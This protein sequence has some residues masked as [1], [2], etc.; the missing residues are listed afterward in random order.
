MM[1]DFPIEKIALK[2]KSVGT[3]GMYVWLND[4][5]IKFQDVLTVDKEYLSDDNHFVL[6][7]IFHAAATKPEYM[8]S[9]SCP[10]FD[11]TKPILLLGTIPTYGSQAIT[12]VNSSM[13]CNMHEIRTFNWASGMMLG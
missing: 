12:Y 7:D 2:I 6:N 13:P 4:K 3:S 11:K 5:E 9:F 1:F 8:P 10:K